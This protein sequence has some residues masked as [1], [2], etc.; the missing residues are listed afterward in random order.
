MLSVWFFYTVFY[1]IL[2][3]VV[4]LLDGVYTGAADISSYV[5]CVV[6]VYCIVVVDSYY[7]KVVSYTL[8][9]TNIDTYFIAKAGSRAIIHVLLLFQTV[10]WHRRRN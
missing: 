9:K 3:L 7:E 6:T 8:P 10:D 1:N 2:A 4:V 5:V